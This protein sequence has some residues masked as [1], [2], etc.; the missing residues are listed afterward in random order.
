MDVFSFVQSLLLSAQNFILNDF[1]D[2]LF[3]CITESSNLQKVME[4]TESCLKMESA[5]FR[6]NFRLPRELYN[7]LILKLEQLESQ[8][9]FGRP[10]VPLHTRFL[11]F[12]SHLAEPSAAFRRGQD[13]GISEGASC[14]VV[15]SMC[16]KIIALFSD[17]I[18]FPNA[19]EQKSSAEYF[20]NYSDVNPSAFPFEG[21]LLNCFYFSFNKGVSVRLHRCRRWNSHSYF[22]SL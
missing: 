20:A 12:L 5:Q 14:E 3:N 18:K 10:P 15:K 11:L 9:G 17:S 13:F 19:T 6:R 2:P 1:N 21:I 4:W 8:T 7:D 22:D 16:Q